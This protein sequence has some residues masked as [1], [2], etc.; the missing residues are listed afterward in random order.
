VTHTEHINIL[1][2]RN[3]E[4]LVLGVVVHIVI[5]SLY[6]FRKHEFNLNNTYKLCFYIID[7]H[8]SPLKRSIL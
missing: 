3:A 1:C 6:T 5:T 2:G 8:A 4:L 7:I